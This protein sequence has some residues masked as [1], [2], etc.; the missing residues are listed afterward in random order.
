MA[1]DAAPTGSIQS[2]ATLV[3]PSVFG[4][5]PYRSTAPT[6]ES[7][8]GEEAG[9][10]SGISEQGGRKN[11]DGGVQRGDGKGFDVV[12]SL[13]RIGQGVCQAFTLRLL[14]D[15]RIVSQKGNR[16]DLGKLALNVPRAFTG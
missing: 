1:A 5:L 12:A 6:I 7:N 13:P 15:C 4:D 2:A 16:S 3:T 14:I 11:S 8:P 9:R 10:L